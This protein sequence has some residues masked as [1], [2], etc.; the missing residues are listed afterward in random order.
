[1]SFAVSKLSLAELLYLHYALSTWL[2][3][4]YYIKVQNSPLEIWLLPKNVCPHVQFNGHNL[5]GLRRAQLDLTG[6]EITYLSSTSCRGIAARQGRRRAHT[7]PPWIWMVYWLKPC[8]TGD[9]LYLP[10]P[11]SSV[12]VVHLGSWSWAVSA[13]KAQ[14][15]QIWLTES[16]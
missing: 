10:A 12:S 3:G 13:P 7:Q 16:L 6:F 9:Q 2:H 4:L 15:T 5:H 14:I 11:E 8:V 1:M